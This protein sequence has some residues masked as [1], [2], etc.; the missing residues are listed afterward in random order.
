MKKLSIPALIFVLCGAIAILVLGPEKNTLKLADYSFLPTFDTTLL[1]KHKY[2]SLTYNDDSEQPYWVAYTIVPQRLE[3][4][5]DRPG[6]FRVDPLVGTGTSDADDY[7]K[8]GYDRGHLV[9]AA[10]MQFDSLA[11]R[12][13]FFYSNISPQL[14]GFNRGVWKRLEDLTR[15]QSDLY[16]SMIVITGPVIDTASLRIGDNQVAIPG[17]FYKILIQFRGN[18]LTLSPYLIPHLSSRSDLSEYLVTVD[19]IEIVTGIDFFS[20]LPDKFENRI[21]R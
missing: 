8:S 7:Y 14:P 6:Y 15:K 1:V 2:Y 12:E 11:I 13:T 17:S 5:V 20:D 10:D 4:L 16:D 9:P 3:A 19:S 18:D 21:E